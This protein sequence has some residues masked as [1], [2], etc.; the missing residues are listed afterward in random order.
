MKGVIVSGVGVLPVHREVE[1]GQV[2]VGVDLLVLVHPL[3]HHLQHLTS[4]T[5]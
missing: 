4:Q 2:Y 1:L 5:R 3:D